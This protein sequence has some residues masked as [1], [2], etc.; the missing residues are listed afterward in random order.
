VLPGSQF[1]W[2]GAMF[3]PGPYPMAPVN[4]SSK[5]RL[6]FWAKGDGQTCRVMVFARVLGMQPAFQTFQAGAEWKQFSFP[7]ASFKGIDG[8]D[9]MSIIFTAGP[10]PGKFAFEIDDVRLE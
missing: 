3:S 10:Q 2:A 4:L 6:S 5:Q 7:W 9:V 8:H 1:P